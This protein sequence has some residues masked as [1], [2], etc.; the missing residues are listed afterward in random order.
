MPPRSVPSDFRLRRTISRG[1][2]RLLEQKVQILAPRREPFASQI[3]YRR[4]IEVEPFRSHKIEH[5]NLSGEIFAP[6]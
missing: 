3:I 2:T 6:N 5:S 1:R 4:F